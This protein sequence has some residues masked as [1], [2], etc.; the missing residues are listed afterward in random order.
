MS[1]FNL[2][3][4]IDKS[5]KAYLK[6]IPP[7]D[8]PDFGK[9]K[10]KKAAKKSMPKYST[11]L[12]D[13]AALDE[14]DHKDKLFKMMS[15]SNSYDK[16]PVHKALYDA[17]A[18]SLSIDE[19]DMDK[20]LEEPPTLNKRRKTQSKSSKSTKAPPGPS[21]TKKVMD[22]DEHLQD[23]ALDDAEIEQ[24]ADMAVNDVPQDDNAPAQGRSK[25]FKQ[26]VVVKAE[27]PD[28]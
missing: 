11:P 12:F 4:A 8:V 2:P 7:K 1:R 18:L 23:G 24:D 5:I 9:I 17:L 14:F 15:V 10:F 3:K 28:P 20:Q 6:N 16:H 19:D 27:T 26:D 22:D 21:T 25:W 13:Q